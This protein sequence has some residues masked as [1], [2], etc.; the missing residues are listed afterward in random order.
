MKKELLRMHHDDFLANHFEIEKI[1]VLMQRKFYLFK[2]TRNVK[3]Y[4]KDYNIY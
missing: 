3:K 1:C 4:V 2:M